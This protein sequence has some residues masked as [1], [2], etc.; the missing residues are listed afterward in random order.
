MINKA[1]QGKY[2]SITK[3][4][5]K[6]RKSSLH[7]DFEKLDDALHDQF[8]CGVHDENTT[9]ELFKITDRKFDKAFEEGL[10]NESAVKNASGAE[11]TWSK[12]DIKEVCHETK[13]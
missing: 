8:V 9:T 4:A 6:L 11:K 1:K 13:F 5:A 10:A 2:E 12:S 3:I 7:C